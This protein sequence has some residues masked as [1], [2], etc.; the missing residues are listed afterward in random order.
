MT[1]NGHEDFEIFASTIARATLNKMKISKWKILNG[2]LKTL[3]YHNEKVL[4][5][6]YSLFCPRAWFKNEALEYFSRCNF[7][8]N[9]T[10]IIPVNYT[11]IFEMC[12]LRN[13]II[14]EL[15]VKR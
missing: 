5:Y 11:S 6:I 9:L 2:V 8:N 13:Y 1:C 7:Q 4:R 14:I 10:C 12:D 15:I 3:H